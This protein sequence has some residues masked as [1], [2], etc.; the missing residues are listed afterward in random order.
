MADIT[1]AA[2]QHQSSGHPTDALHPVFEAP[3]VSVPVRARRRSP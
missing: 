2:S 3:A 1:A